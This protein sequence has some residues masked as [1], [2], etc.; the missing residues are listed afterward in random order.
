MH[1]VI[2][3]GGGFVGSHLT[4]RLL[5]G[6]H[7][8]AV[9]DNFTTGREENLVSRAGLTVVE[10]SIVD[11]QAVA[12]VFAVDH[13][14]V[15]VHAAAS[16]KD[17]DDWTSDALTNVVGT[18]RVV[19]AARDAGVRRFIYFQTALCYGLHPGSDPIAV[20]H[21]L[22]PGASSYAISKTAG[23]S[24]V[25]LSGLEAISFRL[26]NAY[27][28]RNFSGPLPIFVERLMSG[29][30]CFVADSRR[31][32]I[33]I[34]DLVDVVEMAVFGQ[35]R[36]G[37]YHVSSGRDVSILDL[38]EATV[39]ALAIEPTH[40]VDVRPRGADDAPSILLDPSRTHD[41]FDWAVT[42]PLAKGVA[43]AVE[44]YRANGI[45]ETYT[46]LRVARD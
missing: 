46:H 39:S 4:D 43:S 26:A 6:G 45:G 15:V 10:G 44:F 19:R 37:V 30:P 5:A 23:E 2:T 3:G 27:G 20:D 14:D 36:R 1:V 7:S 29:K 12:E 18:S 34:S 35:G 24:Y 25:L 42:T 8:V 33:F 28:P 11:E 40:P 13:P 41:D 31:D 22:D 38:Y 21:P 32:F 9:I 16:Y 17:P